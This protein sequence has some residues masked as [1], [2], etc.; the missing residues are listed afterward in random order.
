VYKYLKHHEIDKERWDKCV[1]N[2]RQSQIFAMSYFLDVV[3][4]DWEAIV[5]EEDGQYA[6]VLPVP[7][8]KKYFIRYIVHPF[9]AQQLGFFSIDTLTEHDYRETIALLKKKFSYIS[10]YRFNIDNDQELIRELYPAAVINQTY[11]LD[12]NRPYEEIWQGYARGHKYSVKK[13]VALTI[14][15]TDD[16]EGLLLLFN[17]FTFPGY[18]KTYPQYFKAVREL[19]QVLQQKNMCRIYAAMDE[20]GT[21]CASTLILYFK[22]DVII[23]KLTSSNLGKRLNASTKLLDFIILSYAGKAET[24]N[25]GGTGKPSIHYYYEGFGCQPVSYL[26]ISLNNLPLIS[27]SMLNYFKRKI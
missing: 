3:S 25:F 9:F 4:P 12:L 5:K 10:S 11:Y 19:Y 18:S 17:T 8:R 1:F 23:L 16:L 13:K 26:Q 21:V 27:P 22:K 14:S 20:S 6:A 15:E 24:C 7:Q 2:S